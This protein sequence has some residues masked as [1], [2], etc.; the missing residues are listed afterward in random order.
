MHTGWVDNGQ[1]NDSK[2]LHNSH[3]W[4]GSCD[5]PLEVERSEC[6]LLG[7]RQMC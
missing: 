1:L 3:W 6:T 7:V 4:V 5:R 2:K